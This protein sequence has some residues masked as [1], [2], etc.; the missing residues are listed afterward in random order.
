MQTA[1]ANPKVFLG[2]DAFACNVLGAGDFD[3]R[4]AAATKEG[5]IP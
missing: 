3:L 4:E 5:S 2:G 1:G